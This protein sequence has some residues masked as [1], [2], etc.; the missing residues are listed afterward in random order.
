MK[1]NTL[2]TAVLAGLTGM[3]GMVSVS[4]AVNVNP[5][6]L[7]QVLLYPYY[8]ARGGNATLISIVNTTERGK[9]VKIRFIEALNSREV[10]D[11]NIYMSPFD[12]WTA[13]VVANE[14]GG[15]KM[16][17]GDRTCTVPYIFGDFDGEQ[18]FLTIELGD[19]GPA[20]DERTASGYIEV[21]EMG[22]LLPTPETAPPQTDEEYI[23]WAVKHQGGVPN[24]C[25]HLVD[26][27]TENLQLPDPD[28]PWIS[29]AFPGNPDLSGTQWGFDREL[30]ASGGIFGGG[31][32][33]NVQDGTMFTY[34]AVAIDGFWQQ[35][36]TRHTEPDSLEPD[37][38]DGNEFISNIFVNGTVVSH[39]WFPADPDDLD[40]YSTAALNAVLTYNQV[41]NEYNTEANAGARTEWVM[42]FPTKRFHTD[43]SIDKPQ[44]TV[45]QPI[46][47]FQ[48]TWSGEGD[49]F[50]PA[51]EAFA[52][53]VPT[54]F[55][56]YYETD[57]SRAFDRE[58]APDV[59]P[60]DLPG[61][62]PPIVS[63]PPDEDDDI[64]PPPDLFNLCREANVVRFSSGGDDVPDESEIL[65]EPWRDGSLGFSNFE[66]PF[67]AGW[68]RFDLGNIP[69][70]AGGGNRLSLPGQNTDTSAME[71]V[72]GLPV[73]GFA[74][75]T[76]VFD[77]VQ[78]G[79]LANY[80]GSFVHR[81]SRV[82]VEYDE[83]IDD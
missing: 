77:G 47:P 78:A 2:T 80:G 32:I 10:L 3:A 19:G 13:G 22:T 37:L 29:G 49:T 4:N 11:F 76:F 17:T 20:G 23:A 27:W 74:A 57:N 40:I 51:C 66:L 9:A 14:D 83:V 64:P 61:P 1:R 30:G 68:V 34:N 44:V 35:G 41:L 81:G 24:D 8:S 58:E 79:V 73:I 52:F 33:V 6:G 31:S 60:P 50:S 46:P 15:G 21:I 43:A 26:Q 54:S 63:P 12:V 38:R 67:D 69:A 36:T 75:N 71:Q 56:E 18:D 82:I 62:I 39:D 42:T 70:S 7:G 5:D 59:A 72:Q 28:L 45:D 55:D 25:Q 16:L 53:T 65:K 48:S